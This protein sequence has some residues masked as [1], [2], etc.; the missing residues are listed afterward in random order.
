MREKA[1]DI[2][3]ALLLLVFAVSM[4]VLTL[5]FPPPGQPNDPG[6]VA[7]PRIVAVGLTVLAVLLLIRARG[8]EPLPRGRAALRVAGIMVLA[9]AYA[10]VLE[11]IGFILASTLFLLGAM[12]LAGARHVGARQILYLVVVSPGL[13]LALFY[14]FYRLLQVSLPR[15]ILEGLLF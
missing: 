9:V 8:G 12:L 15:G 4:F 13:S 2:A 11:P 7:L 3:A 14:L 6:T 1:G 10:A 5:G